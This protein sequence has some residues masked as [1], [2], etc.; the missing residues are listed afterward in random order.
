MEL[1]TSYCSSCLESFPTGCRCTFDDVS[2]PAYKQGHAGRHPL[3][4]LQPS[5]SA[6]H[7]SESHGTRRLTRVPDELVDPSLLQAPVEW[8]NSAEYIHGTTSALQSACSEMQVQG[9]NGGYLPEGLKAQYRPKN[10]EEIQRYFPSGRALQNGGPSP[11]ETDSQIP[12]VRVQDHAGRFIWNEQES[13]PNGQQSQNL[14]FQQDTNDIDSLGEHLSQTNCH[15]IEPDDDLQP[16]ES[17]EPSSNPI[18]LGTYTSSDQPWSPFM[19]PQNQSCLSRISQC[20]LSN[21]DEYK[22]RRERTSLDATSSIASQ[23]SAGR[24]VSNGKWLC[25]EH[26]CG[27]S[28]KKKGALTYVKHSLPFRSMLIAF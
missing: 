13:S 6:S 15:P 5:P 4:R 16:M 22:D 8:S 14:G 12:T 11:I 24:S 19:S 9:G 28:F 2:N 21:A 7:S 3:T 23:S 1:S 18:Q 10:H 26:N 20:A 27:K 17:P 25:P